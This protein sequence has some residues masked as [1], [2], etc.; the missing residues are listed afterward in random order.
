MDNRY[1]DEMLAQQPYLQFIAAQHV[2]D[3][4]VVRA[5]VAQF[6][7]ASRE[8]STMLEDDL[9]SPKRAPLPCP[10]GDVKMRRLHDIGIIASMIPP[11]N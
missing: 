10:A 11:S 3:D 8:R 9:V 5:I 2:A 4:H 6:R 7:G 1:V